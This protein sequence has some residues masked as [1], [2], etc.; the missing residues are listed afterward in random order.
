MK[1]TMEEYYTV[2]HF[3]RDFFI[4][5]EYPITFNQFN[6]SF[7]CDDLKITTEYISTHRKSYKLSGIHQGDKVVF[8]IPH[9][10]YDVSDKFEI[11][12]APSTSITPQDITV[13]FSESKTGEPINR[14]VDS[15]SNE[16]LEANKIHNIKYILKNT[17]TSLDKKAKF[18]SYLQ[19][20][21]ITFN[22]D[23]DYIYLSDFVFRTDVY[24][25]TLEDLDYHIEDAKNHIIGRISK[26]EIKRVPKELE[27]LI[28]K[29]AAAYSWLMWWENE[30]RVM[31]D[32]TNLARNYYDRLI[33]DVNS[34][35]DK[36]IQNYEKENEPDEINTKL[37]GSVRVGN[38]YE[39]FSRHTGRFSKGTHKPRNLQKQKFLF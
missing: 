7:N 1:H 36:W 28:P 22:C 34:V 6:G 29:T 25:R 18:M 5:R 14:T 3:L 9:R 31:S 26:K 30:G 27:H 21:T 20:I 2:L 24:Q 17:S 32:G 38:P 39:H 33:S 15:E 23:L 12:V 19:S 37:V 8:Q 11:N 16:T 4:D 13:S 10:K 35:I